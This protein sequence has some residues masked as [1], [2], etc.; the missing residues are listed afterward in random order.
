MP[1]PADTRHRYLPG[2]DGLRAIA[3]LGV[4]AYHLNLKWA[5]GGLLGVGVFFT[6]SGYLIT[7]LLV[8]RWD[9]QGT[10]DLKDF[11]LRRAR[12]LLPALAVMLAAV[13][14][15]VALAHRS[16]LSAL[17][18]NVFAA[19][20][21]G[22]NWW[23]I[24]H[25]VSYFAQF[26]PPSPLGHLWSLAVEEQFYLAWPW[27][28]LLGLSFVPERRLW[29]SGRPRLALLTLVAAAGSAVAM[30]LLY[31]PGTDPTRVYDGTDTRAFE[32][33]IGAALAL[34]WPMS[35]PGMDED[36][37]ARRA[38]DLV[39]FAGLAGI[40]FL[41]WHTSQYSPFLYRGGMVVLSAA[42][43]MVLAA[44][45]QPGS[46]LGAVLGWG[47]LRWIG[48]RSYGIYI[49][50]YPVIVLTTPESQHAFDPVRATA[51]LAATLALAEA[52]WLWVEQPIRTGTLGS[53]PVDFG[54][55]ATYARGARKWGWIASIGCLAALAPIGFT[56]SLAGPAAT[57]T[58]GLIALAPTATGPMNARDPG[59]KPSSAAGS[60]STTDPRGASG[61]DGTTKTTVSGRRGAT[62]TTVPAGPPA[63][64][65]SSV[66]HIGDSTSESLVSPQYLPDASQRLTAQYADVGVKTVYLEIYG[67][68][69]V[70]EHLSGEPN[71][72]QIAQSLVSKGYH[73]CWV[74]ALGTN[75]AADIAIGSRVDAATRIR[76][77]MSVI[78]NQPVMWVNATSLLTTGPYANS[79]MQAFDQILDHSCALYPNLRVYDWSDVAQPGWFI[80]DGIHYS[81]AGSVQRA[82]D[83]AQALAKAFPLRG[84][85]PSSCTVR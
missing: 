63:T 66:V 46:W 27:L 39:G 36:R 7:D 11:W 22:S 55:V 45:A 30:A 81:S 58:P 23:L 1:R 79:N 51:Q 82:H 80:S 72:Y 38:L 52:S 34:R 21:Y 83:I 42:T 74:I 28:L 33:L 78:G 43:V 76:Q 18:G 70:V 54:M 59:S 44:V 10:L 50:H 57:Q 69:S 60:T 84:H 15:W 49:W 48:E 32:L 56:L 61:K 16:E 4:I 17:G 25:H 41:F 65:C 20:V 9:G 12:R 71:G 8:A 77:M 14:V 67:G 3:V 47:P 37:P 5:S 2:L 85:R 68:T 24:A 75:D 73:G 6:L 29:K 31:H 64:S 26:G 62:S 19:A 53:R 35:R 40:G 13:T